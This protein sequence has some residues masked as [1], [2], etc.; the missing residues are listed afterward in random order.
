M[1]SRIILLALMTINCSY[2]ISMVPKN[3]EIQPILLDMYNE[4]KASEDTEISPKAKTKTKRKIRKRMLLPTS[5]IK[6]VI[7]YKIY[8]GAKTARGER[9]DLT[10]VDPIQ[11]QSWLFLYEAFGLPGAGIA[12]HYGALHSVL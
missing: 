12:V 3:T 10:E 9:V 7:P 1:N 11:K 5:G 2:I 6:M 4:Y 8:G